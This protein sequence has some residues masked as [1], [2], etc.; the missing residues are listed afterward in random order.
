MD[1]KLTSDRKALQINLNQNIF[2]TFAEIGAG[3][4]TARCFFKVGGAAGTIAKTMSAYDMTFSDE[5]YGKVGRYV[6]RDRL[7]KMLDHEYS[8]LIQRLSEK[9]GAET[10]F[11][12]FANT[13]SAR[14]FKGTN[15]SHGWLGVRFQT[16]PVGPPNDIIIHVRMLDKENLL[17]Q[18]ALGIIGVNLLYG[19]YFFRQNPRHFVESLADDLGV[20]RI[21]VDM[22]EFSGP[23]FKDIDNRVMSLFLLEKR[24]TNAVMF[25]PDGKVLQPSEALYKK[26][27]LVE[28]G[29]FRPVT[30]VN[31]DMIKGA[32]SQF[33]AEQGVQ[34]SDPMILF[35]ITLNNL[36]STGEIN[37]ADFLARSDC[38]SALGYT[39]LIS[40]Y[41]EYYRLSAFFRRYSKEIVGMVLGIN[42]LLEIFNDK[43][44]AELE[45]GVLEALGRLFTNRAKLYVYPMTRDA[46]SKYIQ[47][48][49]L[50]VLPAN[51]TSLPDLINVNDVE[52]QPH[53]KHLYAHLVETGMVVPIKEYNANFFDIFSRDVLNKIKTGDPKWKD[54]VPAP[55]ARLIEERGMFKV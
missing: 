16:D 21:E 20:E 45:G 5:I 40:N 41:P 28:R 3:Q 43:F 36:M 35:E 29:S 38:L 10:T 9:R 47:A 24:L 23:A 31:L 12:V 19:A 4:E 8:L 22:I 7:I 27:I 13:V 30:H 49:H 17:Q 14:N 25:G 1:E 11:F 37:E 55:A 50:A 42:A 33:L 26:P 39:V 32:K 34:G 2:G 54:A 6:S 53:L 46:Y 44:Y 18:Q 15:E 52:V 51:V 48:T